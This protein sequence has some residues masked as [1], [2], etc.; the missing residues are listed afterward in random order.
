VT[1]AIG[2]SAPPRVPDEPVTL[3]AT[4]DEMSQIYMAISDLRQDDVED[5]QSQVASAHAA[6]ERQE[7]AAHT[8]IQQEQA[9][10]AGTGRG[11][12]SSIG[13]FFGDFASDLVQG[14]VGD[15]FEDAGKD[16]E[17]AW[18][19]PAFWSDLETGLEDIGLAAAAVTATVATAG[20]A[21]VAL[22]VLGGIGTAAGVVGVSAAAGA[23]VVKVRTGQFEA[24]ATDASADAT[25]AND[26]I[27]ELSQ[28]TDDMLATLKDKDKAHGRTLETLAQAMETHDD[29]AIA[30]ASMTVRG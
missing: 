4:D 21:G 24:D 11:F 18:N 10:A 7:Q 2:S 13:H 17:E 15:A 30:P 16:L 8:A 5:G 20:A 25:A 28:Q 23:A 26:R 14:R 9:N 29:A 6:T 1:P 3:G 12:F 27:G 22:G 19:S